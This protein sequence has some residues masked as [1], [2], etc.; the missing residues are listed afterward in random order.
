MN[1][2]GGTLCNDAGYLSPL[3]AGIKRHNSCRIS[4][5]QFQLSI[6]KPAPI[7]NATALGSD[8]PGP[9]HKALPPMAEV[10]GAVGCLTRA[11]DRSRDREGAIFVEYESPTPTP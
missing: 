1:N 4:K 7:R 8:S 2:T 11:P 6:L 3:Y 9:A 10:V 5:K